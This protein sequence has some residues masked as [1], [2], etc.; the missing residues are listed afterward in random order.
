MERSVFR[1][2]TASSEYEL[3]PKD[4]PT[5]SWPFRGFDEATLACAEIL[6]Y[7]NAEGG[8]ADLVQLRRI[9]GAAAA[10][11]SQR[12]TAADNNGSF[13]S[14]TDDATERR[15]RR[16]NRLRNNSQTKTGLDQKEMDN[17][18]KFALGYAMVLLRSN[19]GALDALAEVMERDGTVEECIVAIETCDNVS[20]AALRVDYDKIRRERFRSEQSRLSGWI[21]NTF[22]AEAKRLMWKIR[23]S[24]KAEVA[25]RGRGG[26]K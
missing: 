5:T 4:D 6:A 9:Y 16:D 1:D 17:R 15:L 19:L 22:W 26:F 2:E 14:F 10:S 21:E 25:E 12:Q 23:V 3:P 8:A 7:G 18:T 11:S 20:G 24:W 13:G